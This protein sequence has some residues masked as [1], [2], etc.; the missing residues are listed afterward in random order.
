MSASGTDSSSAA[1]AYSA[2]ASASNSLSSSISN[3][4]LPAPS[5]RASVSSCPAASSSRPCAATT[6]PTSTGH[7]RR[8]G[9]AATDLP[10]RVP[11]DSSRLSSNDP[12]LGKEVSLRIGLARRLPDAGTAWPTNRRPDPK[13]PEGDPQYA[14]QTCANQFAPAEAPQH[15][16]VQPAAVPRAK[17]KP[18]HFRISTVGEAPATG[19]LSTASC[20]C[21][22]RLGR[23]PRSHGIVTSKTKR[24]K[25][26]NDATGV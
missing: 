22:L 12:G 9:F 24:I 18:N 1:V 13:H 2:F 6:W 25:A 15:Q 21:S 19:T 26:T 17:A 23:L 20:A 4:H 7:P 8:G 14:T 3:S 10:E 11:P 16:Q 5:K